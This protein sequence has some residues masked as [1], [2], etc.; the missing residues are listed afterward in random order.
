MK[1]AIRS[2]ALVAM[3]FMMLLTSAFAADKPVRLTFATQ[4]V[5]TSMYVYASALA[6]IFMK[7][8]P[9]GSTID[10]TTT[11]P[12]GF[13]APVLIEN[14]DAEITLGNSAPALWA[15]KT[16]ILGNPPAK[17]VKALAGGLSKDF[18][19]IL[20]TQD[21]VKRTG[22]KT[23]EEIVAKKYPVRVA[24][25]TAGSFGALA[26]EKVFEVLGVT[27]AD[28][29]SWGGSVTQ[30]GS[31]AI[32]S[33]LKDNKADITI[34]H[35]AAGQSATT[36]LCMTTAMFF[37]QLSAETRKKLNDQGFDNVTIAANTWKGQTNEIQSVG[38]PQTIL[39]SGKLGDDIVYAMTKALCENTAA[40]VNASAALKVF[41]PKTAW[42]PLKAGAPLHPGAARYYREQGYMK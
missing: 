42:E 25:K 16:G 37:P 1:K 4:S 35:L 27:F 31:D 8:L 41:D 39:V 11:S 22:I 15:V 24:I 13:G 18:I 30:T 10:I 19:N 6:N 17:N 28:I 29:K 32:V 36:E 33:L 2:I 9:A 23:V 38:S 7:G 34:D 12:G 14:G 26:C 20:F 21:F 3:L 5:G 40:L